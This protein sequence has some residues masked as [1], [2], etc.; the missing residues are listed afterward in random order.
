MKNSEALWYALTNMDTRGE[1]G[2]EA[3]QV[4]KDMYESELETEDDE[5][6]AFGEEEEP[7]IPLAIM[8]LPAKERA[9]VIEE[10]K[11]HLAK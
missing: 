1:G 9:L 4:L 5:E 2:Q 7:A 11:K 6:R 8:G 3:Y 10:L